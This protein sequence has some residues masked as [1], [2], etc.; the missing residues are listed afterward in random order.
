MNWADFD[1]AGKPKRQKLVPFPRVGK[2]QALIP[3]P[4]TGKRS[5]AIASGFSGARRSGDLLVEQLIRAAQERLAPEREVAA[6]ELAA[7]PEQLGTRLC[8]AAAK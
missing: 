6:S 7:E 8:M 2:R 5:A 3:F 4:R 1:L